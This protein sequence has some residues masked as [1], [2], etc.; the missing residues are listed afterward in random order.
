[1]QKAFTLP[2]EIMV[3][4]DNRNPAFYGEFGNRQPERDIKRDGI[5][6]FRNQQIELKL[7]YKSFDFSLQLMLLFLDRAGDSRVT[8]IMIETTFVNTPDRPVSE[9]AV[10]HQP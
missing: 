5:G 3:V 8:G 6:I 9:V 1:M 4:S 2:E 7:F 10:F